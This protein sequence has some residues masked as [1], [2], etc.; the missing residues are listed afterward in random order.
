MIEKKLI[1]KNNLDLA[2]KIQKKIFPSFN[3]YNNYMSS[4]NDNKLLKYYLLY[5]NN[6]CIGI[7]GF[8]MTHEDIDSGWLG[9]FGILPEYRRKHLGTYALQMFFNE[10][11]ENGCS[12]AR[13]YTDLYDNYA[14]IQ[15]YLK[16]G[17][18]AEIYDNLND[19]TC[20]IGVL[21]FSKLLDKSKVFKL[22]QSRNLNLNEQLQRQKTSE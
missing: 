21:V 19:D 22:W 20:G 16:N 11:L 1:T 13:L 10:C 5:N 2:L 4:I 6:T 7:S 3:A 12:H 17:M 8:Y 9:W 18:V 14:T 15:F